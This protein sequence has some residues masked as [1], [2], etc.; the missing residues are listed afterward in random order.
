MQESDVEAL[1]AAARSLVDRAEAFFL[2][3]CD[4][5]GHAVCNSECEVM[6]TLTAFL[7]KT[8]DGAF[9]AGRLKQFDLGLANLEE[10]GLDLLVGDL[11]DCVA[12]QTEPFATLLKFMLMDSKR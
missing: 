2:Y 4:C 11:F 5:V 8:G 6:D 10:S 9:R 3:F 1:C 7:D 12:L